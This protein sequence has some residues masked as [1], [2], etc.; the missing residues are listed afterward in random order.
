MPF[1]SPS[2]LPQ[3]EVL[4][5]KTITFTGAAN[6]GAVGNLPIFTLT[7]NG[8]VLVRQSSVF[9]TLTLAGAT[10]TLQHGVVGSLGLFNGVATTATAI[11]TNTHWTAAATVTAG[12]VALPATALNIA[13][14]A[15]IVGTVAVSG[16][17]G[18]T[19]VYTVVYVPLTAGS[20]LS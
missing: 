4:I 8:A 7:T 15:N 6:L 3:T 5:T 16:I 19:L 17:T 11:T 9:C 10:A 2:S 14:S 13:I 18:G 20:S 1:P 12:G